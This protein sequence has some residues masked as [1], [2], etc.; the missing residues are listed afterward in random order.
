[1]ILTSLWVQ[2]GVS[3]L[4]TFNSFL[5]G[6]FLGTG[7]PGTPPSNPPRPPLLRGQFGIE[8]GSSDR[9]LMSNQCRIDAESMPNRHLKSGR[10]GG[11]EGE[12]WGVCA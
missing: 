8:I 6:V 11:F 10:R 12:V 3:N 4:T 5:C 9:K 7:P 2:A 1:M